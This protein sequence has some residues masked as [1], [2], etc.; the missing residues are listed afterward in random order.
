MHIASDFQWV[1]LIN[2]LLALQELYICFNVEMDLNI[3]VDSFIDESF[4]FYRRCSLGES[5][6]LKAVVFEQ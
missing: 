6:L 3:S 2:N 1:K 4:V 5:F